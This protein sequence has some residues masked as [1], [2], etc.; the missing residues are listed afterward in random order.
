MSAIKRFFEK[1]KADAKFKLAGGGQKLGDAASA[2]NAAQ[3]RAAAAASAQ[4]RSGNAS[5]SG[6]NR[7]QLTQERR[8]AA[9]AALDRFLLTY[10]YISQIIQRLTRAYF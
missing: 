8:L 6:A 7:G 4:S 1:K 9:S 5:G 10:L 3:K 2:E